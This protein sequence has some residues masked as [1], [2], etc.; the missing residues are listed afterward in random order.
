MTQE[1]HDNIIADYISQINELNQKIDGLNEEKDE[2]N[3]S[4]KLSRE[5]NDKLLKLIPMNNSSPNKEEE[6]EETTIKE[7]MSE[8]LKSKGVN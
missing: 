7:L 5:A 1:E 6:E 4:L 2:L 8:Y 3:N